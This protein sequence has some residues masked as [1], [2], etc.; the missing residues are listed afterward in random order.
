MKRLT[1]YQRIS[2]ARAGEDDMLLLTIGIVGLLI[3]LF[4]L[5]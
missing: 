1:R 5:H 4:A 2:R 3:I